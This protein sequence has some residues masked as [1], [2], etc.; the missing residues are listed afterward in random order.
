MKREN[1]REKGG[2]N[3][4]NPNNMKSIPAPIMI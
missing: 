2:K 4:E 1:E 3:Y